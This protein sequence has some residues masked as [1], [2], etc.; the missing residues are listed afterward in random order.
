MKKWF[1][2]TF[3]KNRFWTIEKRTYRNF[4]RI[5]IKCVRCAREIEDHEL[6]KSKGAKR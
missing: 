3:H 2:R 5:T 1:C 4:E 6:K